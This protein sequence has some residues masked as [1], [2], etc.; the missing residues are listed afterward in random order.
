MSFSL[1]QMFT[2]ATRTHCMWMDPLGSNILY[3]IRAAHDVNE[4]FHANE[5]FCDW[6]VHVQL[7]SICGVVFS[8]VET[9]GAFL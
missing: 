3:R 7:S 5:P 9:A 4:P 1:L 6:N 2:C 8:A